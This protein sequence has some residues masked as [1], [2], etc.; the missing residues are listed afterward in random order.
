MS[1]LACNV[2]YVSEVFSFFPLGPAAEK[3]LCSLYVIQFTQFNLIQIQFH[4]EM[5]A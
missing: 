5:I 3:M 1:H 2:D 4:D